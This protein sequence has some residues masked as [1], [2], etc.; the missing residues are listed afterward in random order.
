MQ[1]MR[2]ALLVVVMLALASCAEAEG[3]APPLNCEVVDR[4]ISACLMDRS[5]GPFHVDCMALVPFG[6][7]ERISGTWVFDFEV[8]QFFENQTEV[9]Q[10]WWRSDGPM[11]Y[12][13]I[14]G[15]SLDDL[16]SGTRNRYAVNVSLYGRRELCVPDHS[17]DSSI[18]VDRVVSLRVIEQEPSEWYRNN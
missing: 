14:E 13:I 3:E 6:Q 7:P 5:A 15:S 4:D 11:T 8:N 10:D 2:I 18:K 17:L 16:V 12:L 9:P 1:V